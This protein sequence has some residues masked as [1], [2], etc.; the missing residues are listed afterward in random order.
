[1]ALIIWV[2]LIILIVAVLYGLVWLMKS[3]GNA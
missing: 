3:T 1:M 2:P